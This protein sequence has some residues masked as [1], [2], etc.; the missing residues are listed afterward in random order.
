MPLAGSLNSV[1]VTWSLIGGLSLAYGLEYR[2]GSSY[3]GIERARFASK[4]Y[5]HKFIAPLP[6]E[7]MHA[8]LFTA[9]DEADRLIE[10]RFVDRSLAFTCKSKHEHAK[11]LA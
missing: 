9:G 3:A 1:D 8:L 4:R 2:N 6:N 10:V 7:T 11:V 5:F